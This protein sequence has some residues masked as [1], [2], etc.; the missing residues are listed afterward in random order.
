MRCALAIRKPHP[1]LPRAAQSPKAMKWLRRV[2]SWIGL[3]ISAG[4]LLFAITAILLSHENF[5]LETAALPVASEV[6]VPAGLAL[7]SEDALGAF[8]KGELGLRTSWRAGMGRG[9]GMGMGMG[10]GDQVAVNF[11]SPGDVV[12][13]SYAPGAASVSI[14]RQER[15]FIA[16]LNRMHLGNGIATGWKVMGDV[17]A[18]GLILLCVTGFLMWGRLHGPRLLALGL[19]GSTLAASAFYFTV[20]A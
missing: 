12:V 18:W 15:G 4:A 16:T 13:A 2:H 1:F 6:P 20:S 8:V 5:G 3:T 11:A 9:G 14:I 17:V 7:D 19:L 10:G